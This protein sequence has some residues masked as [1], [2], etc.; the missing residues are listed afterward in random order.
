MS[1]IIVPI[2]F[3]EGKP[4]S[5]LIEL[6][7][8]SGSRKEIFCNYPN[9]SSIVKG[10]GFTQV[11]YFN[12]KLYI[13]DYNKFIIIDAIDYKTIRV[14]ESGIFNDIHAIS[15]TNNLIFIT[16]T[17]LDS[18][19]VYTIDGDFSYSLNLLNDNDRQARLLGS[20]TNI[21]T[22]KY[23]D[24]R[25]HLRFGQWKLKDKFH[26][27]NFAIVDNKFILTSFTKK[28]LI[29]IS[30]GMEI[31]PRLSSHIHDCLL[32]ND[33]LWITSVDGKIYT[34]ST[35]VD[36]VESFS[37]FVDL[38]EIGSLYGWCRGLAF[39]NENFYIGITQ[40]TYSVPKQRWNVNIPIER[41][42]TGIIKMNIS[43]KE[44]VDFFDF[45]NENIS[46]IFGFVVL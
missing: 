28:T 11:A 43:K 44:I 34:R 32:Y 46:R 42:K 25:S 4:H 19:E 2:S 18:I 20:D 6:D 23:Y 45:T 21:A 39:D 37:E 15:V 9:I 41:T 22:D 12:D 3:I 13:A 14:V 27:N 8:L 5:K 35:N 33:S 17:G 36:I 29:N 40:I 10:K 24:I 16:N 38:F 30:N 26:I 7:T 31:T 1:K